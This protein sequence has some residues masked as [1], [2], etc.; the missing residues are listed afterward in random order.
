MIGAA[1]T[2]REDARVLRG[3]TRYVDDLEP[4]G[5]GHVAFVRSPHAHARDHRHRACPR[6]AD[7]L[8]AVVT[9]ADLAGQ[10]ADLSR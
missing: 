10:R 3:E 6:R 8:I 2:R 1:V 4:A 9:A 5:T 7:G